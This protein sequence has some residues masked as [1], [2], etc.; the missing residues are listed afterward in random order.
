MGRWYRRQP[1]AS[2]RLGHPRRPRWTARWGPLI[3]RLLGNTQP[4]PRQPWVS[5]WAL[6]SHRRAPLSS[7]SPCTGRGG[8]AGTQCLP[9]HTPCILHLFSPQRA[10]QPLCRS[11]H[12]RACWAVQGPRGLPLAS[13]YQAWDSGWVVRRAGCRGQRRPM[14]ALTRGMRCGTCLW[15]AFYFWGLRHGFWAL[16]SRCTITGHFLQ[17]LPLR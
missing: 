11:S 6:G 10:E 14:P 12:V 15:N 16:G 9:I 13:P 8:R 17:A 3:R 4:Q 1:V 2:R 7:E 5:G